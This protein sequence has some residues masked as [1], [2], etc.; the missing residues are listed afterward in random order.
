MKK[1]SIVIFGAG[2]RAREIVEVLPQNTILYIVDNNIEKQ[3]SKIH[4]I[5]VV[6]P[7]ELWSDKRKMSVIM[8]FYDSDIQSKLKS[9]NIN[10]YYSNGEKNNFFNQK[11]YIEYIDEDLVNRYFGDDRV[12]RT[13]K[14]ISVENHWRKSYISEKNKVLVNA[15][16]AQ[17]FK[18]VEQLLDDVYGDNSIYYD[19]KYEFR[20]GM[21]LA[22]NLFISFKGKAVCDLACGHGDFLLHLS[23]DNIYAC[24]CDYSKVRVEYLNKRGINVKRGN[25][26]N[27]P[28]ESEIFDMVTCMECMEHVT[29]PLKVVDEIYRLLKLGGYAII[30]VPYMYCCESEY[31][32]RQFDENLLYSYF[33]ER[34]KIENILRIP[35]LN[36]E[37]N[38][39]IFLV[40]SKNN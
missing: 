18:L 13:V 12:K 27:V 14:K 17:N 38:N 25:V 5:D 4:D 34:F 2:N 32:V 23:K 28:F 8:T 33:E 22:H 26:D 16:K 6:S 15:M 3:G 37:T 7:D 30:T 20:P 21:R 35:Y 11:E 40:A 19:E 39:N 1:D 24:G 29:D 36:G 9:M 31:H 10:Y